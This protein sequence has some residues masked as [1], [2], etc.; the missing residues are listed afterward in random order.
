[1][2]PHSNLM[3][4]FNKLPRALLAVVVF[5]PLFFGVFVSWLGLAGETTSI[6]AQCNMSNLEVSITGSGA[7]AGDVYRTVLLT[8]TGPNQ[9]EL[10]GIPKIR[11]FDSQGSQLTIAAFH[12]RGVWSHLKR[13][14]VVL[15]RFQEASFGFSYADAIQVTQPEP[16]SCQALFVDFGL[17]KQRQFVLF[18][19]FQI[20]FDLCRSGRSVDVTPIQNGPVLP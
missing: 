4:K 19:E 15:K 14:A 18:A 11:I 10:G 12:N 6:S 5:L 16:D 2:A 7:N 1:M 20:P 13:G 17:P 8:N 3:V 9:C